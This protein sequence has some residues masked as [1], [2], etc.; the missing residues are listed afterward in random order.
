MR[1]CIICAEVRNDQFSTATAKALDQIKSFSQQ[2]V[3]LGQRVEI[4]NRVKHLVY[5]EVKEYRY[6]RKCYSSLCHQILLERAQK[7]QADTLDR[8][9]RMLSLNEPSPTKTR[10]TID[11]DLCIFCQQVIKDQVAFQVR[12]DEMGSKFL[13]IKEMSKDENV[14][15]RLAFLHHKTDAFAQDIKYHTCCLRK[16][17]RHVES[18]EEIIHNS[19]KYEEDS[20][21]KVIAD[22]EIVNIVQCLIT[23]I[24]TFPSTDM[25]TIHSTYLELSIRWCHAPVIISNT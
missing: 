14:R 7:K 18:Y 13:L 20:V 25:N 12:S 24:E 15:A 16:V 10:R 21:G 1:A 6:H 8:K 2:W 9:R 5:D 19:C 22:I 4:F 3:R 23:Y 11:K 17:T